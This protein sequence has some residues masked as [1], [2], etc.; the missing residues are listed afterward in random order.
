MEKATKL[1]ELARDL[2]RG[3]EAVKCPCG[4]YAER[5]EST[6]L[7]KEKYGCGRVFDCCSRAFVCCV[8]K[9]RLVGSAV[10]PEMD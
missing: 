7:E 10:A 1:V 4:G 3:A 2:D 6:Q 9:T 8:C 5:V